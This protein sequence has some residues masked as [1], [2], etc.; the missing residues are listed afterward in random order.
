MGQKISSFIADLYNNA[1]PPNL[2]GVQYAETPDEEKNR[3][4]RETLRAQP[5]SLI[6]APT[7]VP[8]PDTLAPP[9]PPVVPYQGDR[10]FDNSTP[11]PGIEGVAGYEGEGAA[12]SAIVAGRL[13]SGALGAAAAV[14][15]LPADVADIAYGVGNALL[16]TDY[17]GYGIT[18]KYREIFVDPA[19]KESMR[20][21]QY[22]DIVAGADSLLGAL[23][24]GAG[25]MAVQLSADKALGNAITAFVTKRNPAIGALL[26]ATRGGES[27]A[28]IIPEWVIGMTAR[29]GVTE[30]HD[31]NSLVSA[32]AAL[33]EAAAEGQIMHLI[34]STPFKGAAGWAAFGIGSRF[35]EDLKRDEMSDW[36]AYKF[37]A[38]ESVGF[39]IAFMAARGMGEKAKTPVERAYAESVLRQ[40][41]QDG[42]VDRRKLDYIIND[43]T[44]DEHVRE[45]ANNLKMALAMEQSKFGVKDEWP[46]PGEDHSPIGNVHRSAAEELQEKVNAG[47]LKQEDVQ[48]DPSW[49]KWFVKNVNGLIDRLPQPGLSIEDVGPPPKSPEPLP[50]ET[51]EQYIHRMDQ[52]LGKTKEQVWER[53]SEQVFEEKQVVYLSDMGNRG[54]VIEKRLDPTRGEHTYLVKITSPAGKSVEKVFF[55]EEMVALKKDGTMKQTG[56]LD[57]NRPG[58]HITDEHAR[59][60]V[61]GLFALDTGGTTYE[62]LKRSGSLN[63]FNL[64]TNQEAHKILAAIHDIAVDIIDPMRD[65]GQ[66]LNS[67]H[68]TAMGMNPT[69]DKIRTWYE[70]TKNLAQ[71]VTA[72]RISL[73]WSATRV[74]E[75]RIKSLQP[76]ATPEDAAALTEWVKVHEDMQ[77]LVE[78]TISN[79]ARGLGAMRINVE[80]KDIMGA[81]TPQ[82]VVEIMSRHKRNFGGKLI[83]AWLE[84]YKGWMFSNPGTH[85]VNTVGNFA[86]QIGNT[87]EDYTAATIGGLRQSNTQDRITFAEAHAKLNGRLTG[88][89]LS[90]KY[91]V[92]LMSASVDV[93]HEAIASGKS[94]TEA[95]RLA[96]DALNLKGLSPYE[97]KFNEDSRSATARSLAGP[98]DH[99]KPF[100]VLMGRRGLDYFGMLSRS[101]LTALGLEDNYFREISYTASISGIATRESFRTEMTPEERKTFVQ[102]FVKAHIML[103]EGNLRAHTK[104]EQEQIE[105]YA[106]DGRFHKEAYDQAAKDIFAN[107]FVPEGK[108]PAAIPGLIEAG[109][110]FLQKAPLLQVIW[111][112]YKTPWN[113][114]HYITQRTPV[115]NALSS[116]YRKAMSKPGRERDMAISKM[117]YGSMLYGLAAQ[118]YLDGKLLPDTDNDLKGTS[119]TLGVKKDSF[120]LN[121]Y[122]YQVGQV[123]PFGSYMALMART[124]Y[125]LHNTVGISNTGDLNLFDQTY[126]VHGNLMKVPFV[127]NGGQGWKPAEAISYMLVAG[128]SLFFDKS[129]LRQV[130]D[131]ANIVSGAPGA[132]KSGEQLLSRTAVGLTLPFNGALRFAN[133][134]TN[135]Y[136]RDA[137]GFFDNYMAQLHPGAI[138]SFNGVKPQFDVFGVPVPS[139]QKWVGFVPQSKVNPQ[140]SPIR[141]L[142]MKLELP[143]AGILDT[144]WRGLRLTETEQLRLNQLVEATGVEKRL[145]EY[146]QTPAFKDLKPTPGSIGYMTQGSIILTMI[147]QSRREA[148]A[149]L[150]EENQ[151]K[152][153]ISLHEEAVAKKL[154]I[155][156]DAPSESAKKSGWDK[157]SETFMGQ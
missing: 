64:G 20:L 140:Q 124:M 53:R 3:L 11:P 144:E 108:T 47:E 29:R 85:I 22:T 41:E 65:N 126:D 115:L 39:H 114:L 40:L 131:V 54:T 50:Q 87:I 35:K 32:G 34:P 60:A 99:N 7:Y 18:D 88:M 43:P 44:V 63:F 120:I 123:D 150:S 16:R 27:M 122:S 151:Q 155:R 80:A 66:S 2:E 142:M 90:N 104:A 57:P 100:A 128:S 70:G 61:E 139:M 82:E 116:E 98:E 86:V 91:M 33:V 21:Q 5:P 74:A 129:V 78:G 56:P 93:Y 117:I 37:S 96:E 36:D 105:K 137:E 51:T 1:T 119:K 24:S 48:N 25:H 71:K 19:R 152:S 143:I 72:A 68:R 69:L 81:R 4:A 130:R 73:L 38:A 14:A 112:T 154:S 84:L 49:K 146:I 45:H 30:Y 26:I 8:P 89:R 134:F 121:G 133:G 79:I 125:A 153:G 31:T 62:E 107:D 136:L 148:L 6:S 42:I 127:G 67:I 132:T 147:R 17:K 135:P 102:G 95:L 109:R 110:V 9:Q 145:N 77:G 23:T 13:A 113:I 76:D 58:R 15:D 28:R 46:F 10:L 106:K 141:A 94:N 75:L 83:S 12:G 138:G 59:K 92:D 103:L 149:K 101:P 55:P 111:P 157:L 52:L 97:N 118:L 156:N